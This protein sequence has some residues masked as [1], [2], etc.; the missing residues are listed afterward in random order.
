MRLYVGG[1]PSFRFRQ[2]FGRHHGKKNVFP[3]NQEKCFYYF[4]ARYALAGGLTALGLKPGDAILLPSYNCG[5]EIDPILHSKIKPVFYRID[6]NLLVDCDDIMKKITG[7]VKAILV[8]HFLGFPQP[9]NQVGKICSEKNL[10]L[11]EDCAHALLSSLDGKPLGSFG[12]ISIFSLLKTLPVPNGGVSA[13]NNRNID[14]DHYPKKPNLFATLLYATELLKKRTQSNNSVI[15]YGLGALYNG[16]YFSLLSAR[17]ALAAFRKYFNPRG[18]Y[19]VKPDSQLFVEGLRPWGISSLS[20]K[21]ISKTNLEEVKKIRRRNFEYLLSHFL[22]N[23]R[24]ILP[25]RELPP[26]VCP[27]FFP[28]ILESSQQREAVYK[29]LKSRGVITHPWWDRFH[30]GVQWEEFP[31]AVYLKRRLFG[32]PIHQDLTLKHLD[33]VV[34]QFEEVYRIE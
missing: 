23:E 5:V 31:E 20:K 18:L 12:D 11:I 27:L 10:F 2:V 13:I 30:P 32:F 15:E 24:G 19:L 4:S 33:H 28:I 29:R 25:F 1:K 16:V 21:I 26:G 9:V 6:K 8:T 3:L 14:H 7:D 17:L 22:K 34:E